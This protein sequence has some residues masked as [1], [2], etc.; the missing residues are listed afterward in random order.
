MKYAQKDYNTMISYDI[1]SIPIQ[2]ITTETRL[3]SALS[4]L[5]CDYK[6][7]VDIPTNEED[8]TINCMTEIF[9]STTFLTI[10]PCPHSESNQY[11]HRPHSL[12]DEP[13]LTENY[14]LNQLSA[15]TP[16]S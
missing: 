12:P 16:D 8:N 4:R 15:W 13:T 14:L 11:N 6:D 2:Y 3:A 1:S 10:K 5:Y 7:I 9:M